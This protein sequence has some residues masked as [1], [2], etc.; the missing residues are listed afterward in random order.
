MTEPI[1][2]QRREFQSRF[3]GPVIPRLWCPTVTHYTSEGKIDAAR[4]RAQ[5]DHLST[6][7]KGYLIPGSTG[8]GWEMN[9]AEILELLEIVIPAMRKNQTKLLIAV[10]KTDATE[11]LLFMQRITAWLKSSTGKTDAMDA[12][13]EA[14]ICGFTV[15]SPKGKD[16]TVTEIADGIA[17]ILETGL[18]LSLYQLPQITENELAPE[19]VADYA[20]RYPNLI[21]FKD[22]S[23]KDRVV[24]SGL[25]FKG[26]FLVRG[27]EGGYA[28]ALQEHGGRYNGWLLSTAN[29]FAEVLAQIATLSAAG[30]LSEAKALS[31]KLAGVVEAVFKT[32]SSVTAGNAF[33]NSAKAVDHFRAHGSSGLSQTPPRLHAGSHLPAE[34]I[35][36]TG[37]ILQQTGWLPEQGYLS[38]RA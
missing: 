18:P 29:G 34:V 21:L 20:A 31:A 17:P 36:Q 27:A 28:E 8:D 14:N 15:C 32:V 38:K 12:L 16:L 11:A 33:A 25:N 1:V 2:Q 9:E 24:D 13:R 37:A 6:W 7:V 22:T 4:V 23:G 10:L 19:L 35:R 30:K 3:I 26:V 5:L